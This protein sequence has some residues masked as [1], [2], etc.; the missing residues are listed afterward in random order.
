MADDKLASAAAV[1]AATVASADPGC[2][3]QIEGRASRVG[4]GVR[5]VHLATVLAEAL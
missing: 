1:S 4:A 2:L 3:M 5:V